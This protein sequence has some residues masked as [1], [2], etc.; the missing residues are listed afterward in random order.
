M[1]IESEKTEKQPARNNIR[2]NLNYLK[3][4]GKNR[5][6]LF[7]E[8]QMEIRKRRSKFISNEDIQGSFKTTKLEEIE[9]DRKNI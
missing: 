5:E 7:Q 3:K 8:M 1:S 9:E 2:A 4:N 6:A